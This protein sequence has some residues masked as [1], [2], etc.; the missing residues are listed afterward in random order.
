MSSGARRAAV[1]LARAVHTHG[2]R[3]PSELSTEETALLYAQAT[4]KPSANQVVQAQV[5]FRA[6]HEPEAR[7]KQAAEAEAQALA[8]PADAAHYAANGQRTISTV[9]EASL[10]TLGLGH[11]ADATNVGARIPEHK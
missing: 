4:D 9:F 7:A 5:A 2:A 10:G 11:A 6:A 8:K 1:R 3:S